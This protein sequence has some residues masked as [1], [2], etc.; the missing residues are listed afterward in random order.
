MDSM[1]TKDPQQ[2]ASEFVP[3]VEALI[4]SLAITR[5]K[6]AVRANRCDGTEGEQRD[7][8]YH[9]WVG[10][11]G[12]APGHDIAAILDGVHARWKDAG[13]T[14]TRY[15]HLDSGGVNVAA[16]DPVTGNSYSLDSGFEKGPDSYVVGFFNTPCYVS[17]GGQVDFGDMALPTSTPRAIH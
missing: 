3:Q 1:K 6:F 5:E 8:L 15:R 14:I 4:A 11:Q 7:D 2:A 16:T 13:W 9:V 17:P 10:L 12:Y